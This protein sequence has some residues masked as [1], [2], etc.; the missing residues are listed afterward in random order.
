[1]M[2]EIRR[3]AL[4]GRVGDASNLNER[5]STEET[6]SGAS[7]AFPT[8]RDCAGGIVERMLSILTNNV[9]VAAGHDSKVNWKGELVNRD[10]GKGVD[11]DRIR[12]EPGQV[13]IDETLASV[14]LHGSCADDY[15]SDLEVIYQ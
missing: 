9:L 15:V 8:N 11:D 1:M 14:V 10:L 4:V 5:Y 7:G 12:L 13:A 2:L 3:G 6:G